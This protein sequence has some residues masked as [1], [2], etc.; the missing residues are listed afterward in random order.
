M[1][2][3]VAMTT[4]WPLARNAGRT[5]LRTVEAM[6]LVDKEQ[7]SLS[8]RH[9]RASGIEGFLEIGNARE[10]G[11]K[12]LELELGLA[13]EQALDRSSDPDSWQYMRGHL[14]KR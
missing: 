3:T 6:N 4:A 9:T 7:R 5:A 2:P 14:G 11:G 12:L 10:D 1:R 13:R 8:L